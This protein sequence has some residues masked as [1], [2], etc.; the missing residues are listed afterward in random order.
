MIVYKNIIIFSIYSYKNYYRYAFDDT[1]RLIINLI[2][3]IQ[4]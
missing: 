1:K 2:K 3:S 4:N